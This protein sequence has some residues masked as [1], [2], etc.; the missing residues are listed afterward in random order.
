MA[1]HAWGKVDEK[2]PNNWKLG[3]NLFS[4]VPKEP[5]QISY[6]TFVE[7]LFSLKTENEEVDKELREKYNDEME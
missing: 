3:H 6:K 7:G 5:D 1:S 2:N 4:K